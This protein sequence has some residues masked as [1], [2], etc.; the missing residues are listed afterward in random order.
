MTTDVIFFNR[1][2]WAIKKNVDFLCKNHYNIYMIKRFLSKN[3][4]SEVFL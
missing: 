4:K 3:N 2:Y 1:N